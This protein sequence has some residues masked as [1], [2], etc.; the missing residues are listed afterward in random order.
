MSRSLPLYPLNQA[1]LGVGLGVGPGSQPEPEQLDYLSLP[2]GMHT[3]RAPILPER[4]QLIGLAGARAVLEAVREALVDAAAGRPTS[5]IGLDGLSA[6]ELALL[7]QVLGEGE[8]S[9]RV[10]LAAAGVHVKVQES[11][12]TGVFRVVVEQASG[13]RYDAL[14]VAVLPEV[15]SACARAEEASA[16]PLE[17]SSMAGTMNAPA[18]LSELRQRWQLPHPAAHVINL[19]LLPLTPAD[20]ECLEHA[21]GRGSVVILSR[22]YGNCRIQSTLRPRTWRVAYYNSQDSLILDTIELCDV[23]EVACAAHSDLV[24]SEERLGEV[25]VWLEQP[26]QTP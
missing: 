14:E 16:A 13:P 1:M 22:G 17:P 10:E 3:Y 15:L 20:L 21:L 11:V 12:F 7:S 18:L 4:E 8:V 25:L 23:P 26:E 24:D 19:T 9:A 5:P 2:Q 6:A